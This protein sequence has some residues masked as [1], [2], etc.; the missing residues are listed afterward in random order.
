MKAYALAGAATIAAFA[1]PST[2]SANVVDLTCADGHPQAAM[3]NW[4]VGSVV[5][6]QFTVDGVPAD[7]GTARIATDPQTLTSAAALTGDHDLLVV[8]SGYSASARVSCGPTPSGAPPESA[9]AQ[10]VL[11]AQITGAPVLPSVR[12][13]RGTP[14][15]KPKAKVTCAYLRKVGAGPRTYARYGWTYRCRKIPV[16]QRPFRPP[17]TG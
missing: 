10:Q 5:G 3:T 9:P 11:P 15:K 2:A 1:I 4:R 17:V 16:L 12:I 14:V 6:Y 7:S 8:V 13:G